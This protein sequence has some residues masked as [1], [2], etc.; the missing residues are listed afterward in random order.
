MLHKT[1]AHINFAQGVD[2]KT[3]PW[4]VPFG[5]FLSLKNTIFYKGGLLKKRNG[6]SELPSLI[7]NANFVTTFNG[8]L[9]AIGNSLQAF[10]DGTDTWVDRGK[11]QPLSI[12]TLPLIRNNLNQSQADT[13][14]ASNGLM[15]TVY[16]EINNTTPSY[17]YAVADSITGQNIISPTVIPS[18]ASA[19]GSPKVFLLGTYFIIVYLSSTANTLKYFAIS[20]VNPVNTMG[21]SNVTSNHTA[22]S[23]VAFDAA[24]LGN[25]LYIAWNGSAAS[26]VRMAYITQ[27]LTFSSSINPDPAH[28][29]NIMSVTADAARGVIWVSYYSSGTSNGYTLAVDT[30][31]NPILAATA[32]ITGVSAL[33]IT[34]SAQNGVNTVFY[35]VSNNY[36]YDAAI[37]THF[38]RSTTITQPGVVSSPVTVSRSVGLASKSY[39]INGTIY[40]LAA[41]SSPYQPTYLLMDL[42]GNV[43]SKLAYQNGGG[44]LVTGLPN[45]TVTGDVAQVSYLFKD[46]IQAVNKNTNVPAGSQVNGIYSQTGVGLASLT[47]NADLI[48]AEVGSN[49]NMTGGFLWSYDGYTPV[50]QNFFVYPDSIEVTT[51]TGSGGL[52]AQQY[53]Y[54]VTYEWT[55]N[56]GNAFK[57]APSIPVSITTTTASSTNTIHV[58]TLRLT[59][60]VSNPVK[61]VIYRW[62]TAQQTYYQVTSI[63]APVLNDKTVDQVSY[64]DASSDATILGNNI[65]YTTGGVIENVGPPGF[66]TVFTF[67]S[68]LWGIPGEDPNTAW[69]SKQVIEATPVEMSDLSTIFI[70]NNTGAQG[71]TGPI[72]CGFSMDD[73]AIFFRA[74]SMVYINGTGPDNTDANSQYSP[75][76][77]ITAT[78]GCSNQKSIVFMPNG[79]M[80]EFQSEA[81]NQIWL[82]GRDLSTQYIGA[83]VESLTKNAK[84]LSAVN[85]PGTNQVRFT[86]DSGITLMYDYYFGQWGTFVNVPATSST[87]Y[88]GLHAYINS[89][90]R[91]FQESPGKY[92]DASN[93]VLMSFTTSWLNLAGIQGYIRAYWFYLLGQY[94]SPHKLQCSIAYDYNDAPS[95]STLVTPDNFSPVYGDVQS[96]GQQT[97]FGQDTPFGSRNVENSRIFLDRQRCS[98]FKITVEEVYDSSMGQPAG[99]GLTLSGINLVY[100][101]KAPF[102]PISAARS[103]GGSS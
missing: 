95:Q 79:L 26:G 77:L 78:V 43:I 81:G 65:L 66:N 82:L 44:Y 25:N 54:R 15:C 29:S 24:V 101:A 61:I 3:D 75:A 63:I 20:T 13:A 31:L 90:G 59:Y 93:P 11:I 98:A 80:F 39:I 19:N 28:Q 97:V 56:Q 51:T 23:T 71:A 48:S 68:R 27:N 34:S 96:N 83:A 76:T 18:S 73:K 88:Q 16:T 91:V 86:L 64:A 37:P 58:P 62:S 35:E 87:L 41:Y 2:T 85:I 49:L 32:I 45:V 72:K 7:S 40:F 67:D 92:L 52:V 100:A 38:I 50:E 1:A 10:S 21:P 57:S 99:E 9:T 6:Y 42:N 36:S 70:P 53:F 12:S 14:V 17:K 8:D 4:Q 94:I 102:R 33:N 5:R 55:D 103:F 74:S 47:L 46:L 84:V 89:D 22:S 30:N 60:K 69:F